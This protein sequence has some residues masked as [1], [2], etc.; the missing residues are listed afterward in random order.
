M[1]KINVSQRKYN[2]SV[3]KRDGKIVAFDQAKIT[4]AIFKA[5]AAVGQGSAADATALAETVARQAQI[6]AESS[7]A[8]GSFR[9]N[10]ENSG[11]GGTGLK[12]KFL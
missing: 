12:G 8:S 7:G 9:L 4:A 3:Q 2:F 11:L 10:V 5:L 6:E 1:D